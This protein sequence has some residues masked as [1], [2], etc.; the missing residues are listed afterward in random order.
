MSECP[1]CLG[2]RNLSESE[3]VVGLQVDTAAWSRYGPSTGYHY[4]PAAQLS[5]PLDCSEDR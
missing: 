5:T 2:G 3:R 1:E 4:F